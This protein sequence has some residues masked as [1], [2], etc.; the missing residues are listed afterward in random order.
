MESLLATAA[1]SLCVSDVLSAARG[2]VSSSWNPAEATAAMAWARR[3]FESATTPQGRPPAAHDALGSA[4]LLGEARAC[5]PASVLGA[6][7]RNPWLGKETRLWAVGEAL[8]EGGDG[9]GAL[10]MEQARLRASVEMLGL[11]ASSITSPTS[12]TTPPSSFVSSSSS[13]SFS[14]SAASTSWLGPRARLMRAALGARW[15]RG[16]DSAAVEM[17]QRGRLAGRRRSSW[18]AE[19]A[20][21]ALVEPGEEGEEE[22]DGA[23]DTIERWLLESGAF[24]EA[25]DGGVG[26]GV[27]GAGGVGDVGGVGDGGAGDG[28]ASSEVKPARDRSP[29]SH[30]TR[31]QQQQQQISAQ[32][33][34]PAQQQ[35]H[36]DPRPDQTSSQSL[37]P[38]RQRHADKATTTTTTSGHTNPQMPPSLTEPRALLL[39]ACAQRPRLREFYLERLSGH[40]A[41]LRR[42]LGAHG[43]PCA[44]RLWTGSP[45]WTEL[46]ARFSEL[47]LPLPGSCH[48]ELREA[49]ERTIGARRDPAL[50]RLPLRGLDPWEDLARE[51][52]LD[53][54]TGP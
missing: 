10:L 7:L 41:S 36:M 4:G 16:G 2:P 51:L 25:C 19:L 9:G 49:A 27:G 18:L 50:A 33:R 8:K 35:R 30:S 15:R 1:V 52:R 21:V 3:H 23:R 40:V 32:D 53:T 38:S 45:G 12:S 47:L 5:G 11:A 13:V 37:N 17:L 44:G 29:H 14:S 28:G 39:A 20:L 6:L 26:G 22:D 54:S 43:G 46:R 24:E 42:D 31:Q 34:A 48:S